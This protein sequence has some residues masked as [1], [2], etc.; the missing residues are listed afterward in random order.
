VGVGDED[1]VGETCVPAVGESVT[2]VTEGTVL[3]IV[4]TVGL[5][6]DPGV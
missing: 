2:D 3:G 6:V 1:G 5:V 4:S